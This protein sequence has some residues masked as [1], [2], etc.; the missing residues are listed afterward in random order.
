[1]PWRS[2]YRRALGVEHGQELV[3]VCSTWGSEG[4]FGRMPDLLPRIMADLPPERFKVAALLH[5]AVWQ[6]HGH[7]Q[8]RA[9]T[10]DCREA[11]L[12]LPEPTDDWRAVVVAADHVIG[13]HGSVTAYAA[14]I[15]RRTLHLP[16]D[17]L[18]ESRLNQESVQHMLTS[19]EGWIDPHR[20]ILAQV[21]SAPPT[22]GAA[23][24]AALTSRPGR[25]AVLI[26]RAMYEVLG[27]AEP[28]GDRLPSPVPLP[29][30]C[31]TSA[32]RIGNIP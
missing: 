29:C 3:V 1:V 9:W 22:D 14:G 17:P 6:A 18:A 12:L 20:P 19:R 28:R 27:L 15:G 5:P 31:G 8:V 21:R 25:A 24:A 16:P 11:G 26:R 7:R 2:R 32:S 13:D 10:Q 4:L 23:V 30:T